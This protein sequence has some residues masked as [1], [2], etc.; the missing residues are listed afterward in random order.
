M[1]KAL[2]IFA[3]AATELHVWL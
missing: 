1:G 2:K 3:N